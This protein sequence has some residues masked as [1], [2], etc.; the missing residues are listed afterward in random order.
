MKTTGNR[1]N[2]VSVAVLMGLALPGTA[3]CSFTNPQ[4]TTRITP[5]T[6]GINTVIGPVKLGNLLI[7][8]QD[9]GG[10]GRV[11]GTVT[12]TTENDIIL[13]L[14]LASGETV[15]I[16]VRAQGR[17]QLTPETAPVTFARTG[18][19]PGATVQLR[20][21]AGTTTQTIPVPVL[22]ATFTEY[23]PYFPI[24]TSP[25]QTPGTTRPPTSPTP[26]PTP[27]P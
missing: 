16:P 23:A 12:N 26:T 1:G 6:N 24:R 13:T 2:V 21:N 19:D 15:T 7:L 27:T 20:I 11:I 14:G 18:A 25:A 8:V 22:D 17:A 4:E 3:G 9:A 5:A 10:P